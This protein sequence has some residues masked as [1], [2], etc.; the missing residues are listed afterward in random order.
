MIKLTF[1]IDSEQPELAKTSANPGDKHK[2]H[3]HDHDDDKSTK[4]ATTNGNDEQ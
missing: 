3:Q 1:N 2:Q 4:H